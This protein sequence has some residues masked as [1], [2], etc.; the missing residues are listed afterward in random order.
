M[1]RGW[2]RNSLAGCLRERGAIALHLI[3]MGV[4]PAGGGADTHFFAIIE[5]V[6]FLDSM[7]CRGVGRG[8]FGKLS[9]WGGGYGL[10]AI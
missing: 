5:L 6:F 3:M 10:L 8:Q 2:G 7:V 4:S 9:H 1:G